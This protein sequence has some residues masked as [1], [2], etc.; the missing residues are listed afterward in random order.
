MNTNLL[1]LP[2]GLAIAIAILGAL[3]VYVFDRKDGCSRKFS[4]ISSLL[5][6]GLN[7]APTVVSLTMI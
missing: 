5:F 6:A 7:L 1:L 4:L 3:L 2:V